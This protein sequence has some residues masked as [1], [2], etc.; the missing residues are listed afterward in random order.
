MQIKLWLRRKL[1]KIWKQEQRD[2]LGIN[3]TR[4]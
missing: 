2:K 1:G 4:S 3:R